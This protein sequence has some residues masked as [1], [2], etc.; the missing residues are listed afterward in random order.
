MRLYL[1]ATGFLLLSAFILGRMFHGDLLDTEL[2]MPITV[3]LSILATMVT[4]G[5][6]VFM[7]TLGSDKP[8]AV[9]S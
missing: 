6:E 1:L 7:L 9:R 4:V 8:V 5:A 2:W 3:A